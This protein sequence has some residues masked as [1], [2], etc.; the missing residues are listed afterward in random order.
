MLNA[1]GFPIESRTLVDILRYRGT[2]QASQLAFTFLEDGVQETAHLTYGELDVKARA[3]AT[4]LERKINPGTRAL[5]LYPPGLE[6]IAA[7]FGCLYAGVVAVPAY[8]PRRNQKLARLE[9]I[10]HSCQPQLA[11]TTKQLVTRIANR[12]I[13]HPSIPNLEWIATDAAPRAGAQQY[14]A[15]AIVT[16]SPA[17]LQ[18]TSGSTG[19]PKG[20]TVSH[21]NLLHNQKVIQQGFG[22]HP[23]TN[24]VGWLPLYHDMGLIGNVLQPIYLGRRC[25]LMPPFAFLQRPARWLH[26]ISRY[27]ATTSGGPNFAYDL[28]VGRV[29]PELR[30]GLDLSSWEIAFNGAEPVRTETLEQF[31]KCFAPWGFRSTTFYPCYGMAEATLM[32]TGGA[33]SQSPRVLWVEASALE[34]NQIKKIPQTN[35][36]ARPLVGCGWAWGEQL[37]KIVDPHT[38]SGCSPGQVGEVWVRGKSVAQ[39]YWQKSSLTQDTFKAYLSSTGEGPFLRT[40]DLGFV[41]NGELFITG[42]LKDLLIVQGR[43]HYPQDLELTA[44]NSHPALKAGLGAAFTVEV[45]STEKVVIL[46]EVDRHYHHC[47]EPETV[48]ADIRQALL[49]HHDLAIYRIG[50]VR[51]G[52]LPRTSSGKIR[53][54]ACKKAFLRADLKMIH[55]LKHA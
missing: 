18:Y 44:R 42:R 23:H 46:Q 34:Q 9:G 27:R 53:R 13:H 10:I 20:V 16:D 26:A 15:I 41:E 54:R 5:L 3:I 50:L 55:P 33:K 40:G 43:N 52:S 22:H 39:G 47:L 17:F 1:F 8:P 7:F 2:H 6:F 49:E 35:P 24:V 37:V 30:V 48:M 11:L 29:P 31:T 45:R 36:Q 28:C 21:G 12:F 25:I 32:I 4:L 51:Y 38:L 19:D 14:E